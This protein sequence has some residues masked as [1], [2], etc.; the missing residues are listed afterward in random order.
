MKVLDVV[1]ILVAELDDTW[2][3]PILDTELKPHFAGS[4]FKS[5]LADGQ[6][7]H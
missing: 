4:G 6:T 1:D 2:V 3:G 7:V 5:G